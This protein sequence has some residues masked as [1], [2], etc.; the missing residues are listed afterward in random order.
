MQKKTVYMAG[1]GGIGMS[2]LARFLLQE[3]WMIR[4]YDKVHGERV[5]ELEALGIPVSQNETTFD[6]RAYDEIIYTPAVGEEFPPLQ[7]A[8]AKGM[9][10]RKRAAV[11]GE[12]AQQY[13]TIAVAG[14]HGK[15]STSCI[16]A[17]LLMA[18]GLP[19]SALLGG[20]PSNYRTNYLSSG[21][22][23]LVTE[24]DEY[25][26]S[27]LE[28]QP[29]LSLI[30]ATEADHLDIYNTESQLSETY[31][32]YAQQTPPDGKLFLNAKER[33]LLNSLQN[34]AYSIET[35][36]LE[37]GDHHA[38]SV[39]HA[40]FTSYFSYRGPSVQLQNLRLPMPGRHN[41]ENAIGAIAL[42]LAAGAPVERIPQALSE[43]KG[44]YRRFELQLDQPGLAYID[45]YAHH[46]T[47][48]RAAIEAARSVYPDRQLI[49]AFQPHLYSRTRDFAAGFVRELEAADRVFLLHI[50]PARELSIPNVT[51]NVLYQQ[52]TNPNKHLLNLKELPTALPQWVHKPATV[53]T[54][55]AG[56]I[57][58][59]V[60]ALKQQLLEL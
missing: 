14:T 11:L 12:I 10:V 9:P 38:E 37:E 39:E 42:A 41:I 40:G 15:T 23:W 18:T 49:V 35:Y 27:L 26:R 52:I 4:G 46:P 57:D 29:Y 53:L 44:I 43:F 3:G 13:K 32:A 19:I 2:A 34:A 6:P 24:A 22:E 55:G 50:Y 54:L 5:Q 60:A 30:T 47:E 25:D 1:I 36:G 31:Y 56:D 20:I 7:R 51:S 17:H 8:R 33:T 16:L 28:L 21:K 48:I 58:T 59:Q 45:D